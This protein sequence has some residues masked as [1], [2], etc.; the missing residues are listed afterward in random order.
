V[1]LAAID[2]RAS[3][4]LQSWC[5]DQPRL[6]TATTLYRSLGFVDA[7]KDSSHDYKRPTIV[8]ILN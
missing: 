8:L 1:A 3:W 6:E 4:G 2:W 5:A 7:G